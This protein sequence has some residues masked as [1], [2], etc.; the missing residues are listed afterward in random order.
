MNY[1]QICQKVRQECGIAGIGPTTVL[2]QT[3]ENQRIVTWVATAWNDIQVMRQQ[4]RWLWA[5]TV[6]PLTADGRIYNPAIE[7]GL[8]VNDWDYDSVKLYNTSIGIADEMFL[9]FCPW[10]SF[11]QLYTWGAV[12]TQRPTVYSKQPDDSI[13]FN[14]KLD[15]PYTFHANY[16]ATPTALELDADIPSLPVRYHDLIVWRAC[17]AYAEYEEAGVLLQSMGRRYQKMLLKVEE[18]ELPLLEFGGP[19]A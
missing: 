15:I 5:E 2:E 18:M 1:L 9:V 11:K 8:T 7:W 3:G 19:L 14:F 13:I 16:W 6:Q 12:Q 17:M 10:D 4:W